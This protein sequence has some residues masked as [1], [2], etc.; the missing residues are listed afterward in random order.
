MS[1]SNFKDPR[2]FVQRGSTDNVLS[3]DCFR[4]TDSS[5]DVEIVKDLLNSLRHTPEAFAIAANQ[6]GYKRPIF[7]SRFPLDMINAFPLA[8]K[9]TK[10][11]F[12]SLQKLVQ[13]TVYLFPTFSTEEHNSLSV[14]SLESCLSLCYGE[15]YVEVERFLSIDIHTKVL[16]MRAYSSNKRRL[17][18]HT[19]GTALSGLGA[20]I[21]QHEAD[22]LLG[23]GIW[24]VGDFNYDR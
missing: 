1:K 10:T 12:K 15:M 5:K 6:R 8:E 4:N 16:N 9:L 18:W 13:P 2:A 3:F 24:E 22:H 19:L 23:Y 21:Y 11:H 20:Q 14:R 7:V 17:E